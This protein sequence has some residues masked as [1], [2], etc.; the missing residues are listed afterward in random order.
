MRCEQN[1]CYNKELR[2]LICFAS[3]VASSVDG[4][5]PQQFVLTFVVRNAVDGLHGAG[6]AFK[7]R[8]D[9]LRLRVPRDGAAVVRAGSLRVTRNEAMLAGHPVQV[10]HGVLHR[11]PF[12]HENKGEKSQ[13]LHPLPLR[14]NKQLFIFFGGGEETFG[15]D[16]GH[17]LPFCRETITHCLVD[18][19]H[20]I[21]T[22]IRLDNPL[23]QNFEFLV[24]PCHCKE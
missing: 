19:L 13:A 4:A 23:T 5:L 12:C 16:S 15:T 14:S 18:T 21:L 11:L 10:K 7:R 8:E 1:C 17:C 3:R 6:V 9:F 2:I 24:A 20:P 22:T